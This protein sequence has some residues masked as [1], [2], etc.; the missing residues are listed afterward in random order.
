MVVLKNPFPNL[1]WKNAVHS[2]VR[3]PNTWKVSEKGPLMLFW[4]FMSGAN[5]LLNKP[6]T[7]AMFCPDVNGQGTSLA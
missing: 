5:T 3:A 4:E 2:S 6:L 1:F 7:G